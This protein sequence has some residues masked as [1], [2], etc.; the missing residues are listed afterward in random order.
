MENSAARE[1][2]SIRIHTI[3]YKLPAPLLER[4]V[5]S[6]AGAVSVAKEAGLISTASLQIGDCSPI[7]TLAPHQVDE[8]ASATRDSGLD[9]VGYRFFQA[10]LG[11]AAGHNALLSDFNADLLWIINP[12]T[13]ASPYV[14]SEMLVRM[15]GS[16]YGVGDVGLVEARQLPI[17]HPK[18]YDL[19]TG[20]TGWATTACALLPSHVVKEVGTFDADT[21]FLYCDDVDYSWR[22]RLAGY[23]IMYAPSARIFHDKRATPE[24]HY[25]A[26][27]T[28]EYYAGEAALLMAHKYSRP[29]LVE[30]YMR[31]LDS[32]SELSKK[33]AAEF[34]SRRDSGR[35]PVPI[36]EDHAVGEFP[37]AGLFAEHRY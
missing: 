25:R 34:R 4:F 29:D 22:I 28:E 27:S 14:L 12:D 20:E 8:Y 21:F 24:G 31:G 9:E 11:S 33:A 6:V 2:L 5:L 30:L 23:K 10:N 1:P 13:V 18:V 37:R 26:S 19:E 7:P 3:L 17:E 15:G 36:D 16:A 32:G 35:L